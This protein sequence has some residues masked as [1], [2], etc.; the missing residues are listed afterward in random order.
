MSELEPLP[1]NPCATV[2]DLMTDEV[3]DA[4]H[5]CSMKNP[6]RVAGNILVD[7][8]DGLLGERMLAPAMA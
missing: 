8:N 6:V 5:A 7:A 4:K 3:A 1:A 2:V